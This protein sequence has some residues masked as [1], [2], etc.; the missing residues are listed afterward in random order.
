MS[1]NPYE[2][3]FNLLSMAQ[4]YLQDKQEEDKNFAYQAWDL[5][6]EDGKA[7]MEL[8]KELQPKPYSIEDIKKK[9]TELYEFVEQK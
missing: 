2:L 4:G 1:S 7:N 5:A 8:W 9:A 6:R 3:R